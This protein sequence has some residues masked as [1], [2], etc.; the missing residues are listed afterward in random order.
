MTSAGS[1][2]PR[3]KDIRISARLWHPICSGTSL[4]LGH[5]TIERLLVFP[6]KVFHSLVDIVLPWIHGASGR[7]PRRIAHGQLQVPRGGNILYESIDLIVRLASLRWGPG[8]N[9]GPRLRMRRNVISLS[10]SVEILDYYLSSLLSLINKHIR[11]LAVQLTGREEGQWFRSGSHSWSKNIS[12]P[13]EAKQG[14]AQ[15]IGKGATRCGA[16][17]ACKHWQC[18]EARQF[19]RFVP[20]QF[21]IRNRKE[22]GVIELRERT[23]ATRGG[24]GEWS[25]FQFCR[26]TRNS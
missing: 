12:K 3:W 18:T 11:R 19:S 21:A 2:A 9:H 20:E 5:S 26:E 17:R 8:R 23:G 6:V 22:D 14:Q 10:I 25:A 15:L 1:N 13:M 16:W 24:S 7:A 4:E